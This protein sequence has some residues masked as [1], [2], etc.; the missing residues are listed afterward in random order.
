MRW[1]VVLGLILI[2]LGT[3][4]GE[5]RFDNLVR[6]YFFSGFAGVASDL[7]KGMAICDAALKENPDNAEALVWHGSGILFQSGTA[8]R[9]G[10]I[11][12]GKRLQTEALDELDRGVA[13]RPDSPSTLVPR[14]TT[15]FNAARYAPAGIGDEWLRKA[16]GDFTAVAA[17]N[18]QR[19]GLSDHDKGEVLGALAEGWDRLGDSERAYAYLDRIRV[20]LPPESN[21]VQR[22]NAWLNSGQRPDRMTCLGCHK[23]QD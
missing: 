19:S 2:P 10:D 1:L 17:I 22:A 12:E 11:A 5:P 8:F 18:A 6:G 23:Q 3:R 9:S 14:A 21:Y 7:A 16:L 4:A 13:L 15:L 20:E